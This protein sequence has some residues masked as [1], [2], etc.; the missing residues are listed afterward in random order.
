L[1]WDDHF[2]EPRATEVIDLGYIGQ[3]TTAHAVVSIV[4]RTLVVRMAHAVVTAGY[5]A[6]RRR[7]HPAWSGG[8]NNRARLV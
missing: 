4:V 7:G 1:Q 5:A 3:Q 2:Y 8:D 6:W